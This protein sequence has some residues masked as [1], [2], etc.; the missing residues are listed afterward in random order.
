[1]VKKIVLT[2]V[3]TTWLVAVPRPA[4]ANCTIWLGDCAIAAN[5]LP[6]FWSAWAALIDCELDCVECIRVKVIGA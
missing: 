3:V 4:T 2:L 1:M 5:R 6:S